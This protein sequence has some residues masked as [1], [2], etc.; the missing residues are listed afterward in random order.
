MVFYFQN[1]TRLTGAKQLGFMSASS[2]ERQFYRYDTDVFGAKMKKFSIYK[3][4]G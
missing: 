3:S 4:R 1:I 2:R